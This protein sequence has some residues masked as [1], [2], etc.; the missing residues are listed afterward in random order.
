MELSE[1]RRK[2]KFEAMDT[3]GEGRISL[4]PR[5]SQPLHLDNIEDRDYLEN[6]TNNSRIDS[7]ISPNATAGFPSH[8]D[9]SSRSSATSWS[10]RIPWMKAAHKFYQR[11]KPRVDVSDHYTL[12]PS[13]DGAVV[14]PVGSVLSRAS[15][16]PC[17]PGAPTQSLSMLSFSGYHQGVPSQNHNHLSNNSIQNMPSPSSETLTTADVDDWDNQEWTPKDSS[18][19]AAFPVCGFLP[20]NVRRAIEFSLIAGALFGVIYVVVTVSIKLTNEHRRK[21]ETNSTVSN[22]MVNDDHY[23]E[24]NQDNQNDDVDD[25][26]NEYYEEEEENDDD[27]AGRRLQHSKFPSF[28]WLDE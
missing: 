28:L 16:N 19:G 7:P 25:Y 10:N 23:I 26:F 2:Q 12:Q 20:K 27:D 6:S 22:I 13:K 9:L 4:S 21:N 11:Q 3:A 24:Y 1:I 17:T 18:Y 15:T 14:M 8:Y 5:P